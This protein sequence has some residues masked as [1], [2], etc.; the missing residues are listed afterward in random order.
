LSL[1][2]AVWSTAKR[3]GV[4]DFLVS[5]R[6]D[7]TGYLWLDGLEEEKHFR[8]N[9]GAN[10]TDKGIGGYNKCI[11]RLKLLRW[12]KVELLDEVYCRVG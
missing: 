3:V 1:S 6:K 9:G 4:R 8:S 10:D 5:L 2:T 11:S 12:L 7:A